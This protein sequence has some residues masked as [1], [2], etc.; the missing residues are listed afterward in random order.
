MVYSLLMR[1]SEHLMLEQTN[2]QH[3]QYQTSA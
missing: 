2:C 1:H 3:F